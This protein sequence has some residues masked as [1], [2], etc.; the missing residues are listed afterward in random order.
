M[1]LWAFGPKHTDEVEKTKTK[2]AVLSAVS[3]DVNPAALWWEGLCPGGRVGS[4]AFVV[5]I[6]L[7]FNI[8]K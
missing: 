8:V 7:Q 4:S 1:M 5:T 6:G 3:H 2:P